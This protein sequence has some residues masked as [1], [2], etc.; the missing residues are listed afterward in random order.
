MYQSSKSEFIVPY[1]FVA[2]NLWYS[3]YYHRY[4]LPTLKDYN[5]N[6]ITKD[7]RIY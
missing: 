6:Q 4:V 3:E 7:E 1:S 2:Q 5:R